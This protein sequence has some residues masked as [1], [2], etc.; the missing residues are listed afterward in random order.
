MESAFKVQN[1]AR[2][3]PECLIGCAAYGVMNFSKPTLSA[4]ESGERR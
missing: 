2:L 4:W 1:L 3:E